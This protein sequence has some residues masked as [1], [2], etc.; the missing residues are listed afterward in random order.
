[1]SGWVYSTGRLQS[2]MI[3]LET[4]INT[5]MLVTVIAYNVAELPVLSAL[6]AVHTI[7]SFGYTLWIVALWRPA[8]PYWTCTP[9]GCSLGRVGS[10]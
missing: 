5:Q 4:R 3:L 1:M 6:T 7:S 9:Y 8:T 2:I 10:R